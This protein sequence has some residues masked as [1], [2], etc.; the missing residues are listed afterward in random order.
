MH[1]LVALGLLSVNRH[2]IVV[3]EVDAPRADFRQQLHR[4]NGWQRR[5]D[6]FTER[7]APTIADRPQPEA[8]L[9]LRSR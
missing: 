9:V 7:I 2:K 5:P 4:I 8:E 1:D 6:R 3:V